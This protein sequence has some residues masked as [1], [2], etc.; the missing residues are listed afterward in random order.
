MFLCEIDK[1][2]MVYWKSRL[3]ISC[4]HCLVKLVVCNKQL[5]FDM[6][7]QCHVEMSL[8]YH[9]SASSSKRGVDLYS[10]ISMFICYVLIDLDFII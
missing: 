8:T 1:H 3:I 7:E 9:V 4:C 10:S 6:D 2:C 5:T